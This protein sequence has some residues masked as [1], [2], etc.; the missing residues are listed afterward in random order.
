M[1]ARDIVLAHGGSMGMGEMLAGLGPVIL[2]LILIGTFVLLLGADS[3]RRK[4]TY[5]YKDLTPTSG[6]LF[7]SG[8]Y[9][10]LEESLKADFVDN[11]NLAAEG[12][13]TTTK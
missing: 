4:N 7:F 10:K 2:G 9:F 8:A 6:R 13:E 5:G 12:A 3:R 11:R 1:S